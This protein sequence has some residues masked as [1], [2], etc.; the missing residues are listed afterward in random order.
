MQESVSVK[1][2]IVGAGIAGVSA[3][4]TLQLSGFTDVHVL[5]SL[6]RVGGRIYTVKSGMSRRVTCHAQRG[7]HTLRF[8]GNHKP[9]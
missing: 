6:D 7:V 4:R 3:A 8:V 5:E 9:N 2:V 1:V